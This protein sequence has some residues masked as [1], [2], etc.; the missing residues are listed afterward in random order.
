MAMRK[1]LAMAVLAM[2]MGKKFRSDEP[3]FSGRTSLMDM[4]EPMLALDPSSNNMYVFS[5]NNYG[6]RGCV[7]CGIDPI[8]F[9]RTTDA[10]ET[11]EK[12]NDFEWEYL[13]EGYGTTET[14]DAVVVI[15]DKG[16]LLATYM[17]D[18]NITF[19]ASY[20][21]GKSWTQPQIISGDLQAD[22][23]WI[24]ISP[25]DQNRLYAT[26]NSQWPFEVHSFD[27]GKTWSNPQ[28]LDT[29]TGN[30]FFAC[31][32]VVRRDGTAFIAYAAV[33]DGP[34][35][36][37]SYA[38]VYSSDD[39]FAT[40]TSHTIAEWNG[41]QACP[42]WAE[43]GD[44]YLNGACS[45]GIDVADNVYYVYNGYADGEVDQQVF[46]S[47]MPAGSTIFSAPI[48]VSDA[49]VNAGVFV[50]FPMVA[51][52]RKNGD[53]KVTWMDNRTGMWNI[54]FRESDDFTTFTEES[55]RLS[56]YNK[57]SFQSK[58]GFVFP[59][60]DYGMMLVDENGHTHVVWGEGLGHYAGGTVMYTTTKP[61]SDGSGGLSNQSIVII[62]CIVSFVFGMGLAA[63][64]MFFI[65]RSTRHSTDKAHLTSSNL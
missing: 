3:V 8:L 28:V 40:W 23:N 33:D 13:D 44:D 7:Y 22:K 50:G 45:I 46:L 51:G 12:I 47:Y 15:D 37:T 5:T 14:A 26:F 2:A 55:E 30:Y 24:S 11:W 52:G 61:K 6:V 18:W 16:T 4:W 9:K 10:G 20:D 58:D 54:Y 57:F 62:T 1:L 34:L 42:D 35:S 36:N 65:M 41:Y 29:I 25:S 32:S 27:Q 53:V 56:T 60:G 49:P 48:L 38:M 17:R 19:K 31:G 63:V 39:D 59:Y 21:Q 43:C 64:G